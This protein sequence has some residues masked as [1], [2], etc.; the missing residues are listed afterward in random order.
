MGRKG[1]HTQRPPR[2][3]NRICLL[4]DPLDHKLI[5]SSIRVRVLGIMSL[6]I[7]K[8]LGTHFVIPTPTTNVLRFVS[9][10]AIFSVK[11]LYSRLYLHLQ[12]NMT[13]HQ[14]PTLIYPLIIQY[15]KRSSVLQYSSLQR[16]LV[17]STPPPPIDK[18][19]PEK[20]F[21][22]LEYNFIL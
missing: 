5:L 21:R 4:C 3:L 14:I 20:I 7:C 9:W 18:R 2:Q 12:L 11:R 16:A 6:N 22:R 10:C 15:I 8:V 17:A 13:Y 1:S 19:C